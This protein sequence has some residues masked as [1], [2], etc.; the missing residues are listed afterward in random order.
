MVIH[1]ALIAIDFLIFYSLNPDLHSLEIAGIFHSPFFLLSILYFLFPVLGNTTIFR[2]IVKA[3]FG[4]TTLLTLV[5]L[6]QGFMEQSETQI[7]YFAM[8]IYFFLPGI[9]L[10]GSLLA[11]IYAKKQDSERII[12]L[13]Q[14]YMDYKAII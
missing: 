10:S 3:V 9:F 13:S 7:L 1:L 4:M 12:L 2:G 11:L 6:I 5:T 14:E 8:A